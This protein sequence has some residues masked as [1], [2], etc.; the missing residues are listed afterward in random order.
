LQLSVDVDLPAATDDH[1]DLLGL[2]LVLV[3]ERG[4]LVGRDTLVADPELLGLEV[5][6]REPRLEGRSE[7]ELDGRVLDVFLEILDRV[8]RDKPRC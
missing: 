2:L 5:V 7:A 1:V 6:A 8:A 4:F 3:R